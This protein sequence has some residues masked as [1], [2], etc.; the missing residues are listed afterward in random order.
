MSQPS[1][2]YGLARES[3]PERQ[4]T[5]MVSAIGM[6]MGG[7]YA[8]QGACGNTERSGGILLGFSRFRISKFV[9]KL[10][11]NFTNHKVF[12]FRG[13]LP[14]KFFSKP[15]ALGIVAFVKCG[16]SDGVNASRYWIYLKITTRAESVQVLDAMLRPPPPPQNAIQRLLSVLDGIVCLTEFEYPTQQNKGDKHGGAERKYEDEPMGQSFGGSEPFREHG[17]VTPN[18]GPAAGKHPSDQ[19]GDR[20]ENQAD[21]DLPCGVSKT[22]HIEAFDSRK[23]TKRY[24]TNHWEKAFPEDHAMY[25]FRIGNGKLEGRAA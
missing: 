1:F 16:G 21:N 17:R 22:F 3:M 19:G 15:L 12:Y 14:V 2:K 13:I 5:S 10:L 25:A 7:M 6:S 4:E 23:T 8:L 24:V 9:A 11:L 18:R 20:Q